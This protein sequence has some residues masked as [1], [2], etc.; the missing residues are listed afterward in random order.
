VSLALVLLAIVP[1]LPAMTG[2]P[3]LDDSRI[4]GD[5]AIDRLLARRFAGWWRF[6]R[7]STRLT[8]RLTRRGGALADHGFNLALHAVNVQLV[9][10]AL[11]QVLSPERAMLVAA[12]FAVHPLQVLSAGYVSARAGLLSFFAALLVLHVLLSGNLWLVCFAMP[13]LVFFGQTTKEDFGIY[14][15]TI[16]LLAVLNSWV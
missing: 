5:T 13:A 3:I 11:H 16:G 8:H 15:G 9:F 10:V 1:F 6:E 7:L 12:I 4:D 2:G 14:L